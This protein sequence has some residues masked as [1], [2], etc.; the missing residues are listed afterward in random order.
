MLHYGTTCC[1]G[2]SY[3]IT[4]C[5]KK[6]QLVVNQFQVLPYL[7]AEHFQRDQSHATSLNKHDPTHHQPGERKTPKSQFSL[8]AQFSLLPALRYLLQT[9]NPL[10]EVSSHVVGALQDILMPGL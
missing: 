7:K 1:V 4:F 2:D 10:R 6:S 3:D 9:A 8:R 5:K